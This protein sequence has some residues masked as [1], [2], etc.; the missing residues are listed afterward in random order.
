MKRFAF[1]LCAVLLFS[2]P[3]L[4][5]QE[6]DKDSFPHG[7]IFGGYNYLRLL[8][9]NGWMDGF[10]A[11]V[12]GNPTKWLGIESEF[13]MELGKFKNMPSLHAHI[14]TFAA[15]PRF[16]ARSGNISTYVHILVGTSKVSAGVDLGGWSL[17]ASRNALAAVVGGGVD[18]R[19]PKHA[20]G[21]RIIQVDYMPSYMLGTLASN[22]RL[23]TGVV[24]SVR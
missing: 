14:Y 4:A 12:S 20:L 3:V 13:S 6:K 5:Q 16:V 18:W 24:I 1:V 7:E 10:T 19:R 15:G 21:I 11:S 8:S 22:V 2:A 17:D 23:S 9:G